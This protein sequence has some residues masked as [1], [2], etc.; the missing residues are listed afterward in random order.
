MHKE[1]KTAVVYIITKLE[2]GGAQKICLALFNDIEQQGYTTH[3]ITSAEGT[4]VPQV[5]SNPKAHLLPS[6]TREVRFWAIFQEIKNFFTLMRELRALKKKYTD[7][8]VHTHSTKAGIVGRWAARLVGIKKIIHTVHGFAFHNFQSWFTWTALY[9]PEVLTSLITTAFIFVSEADAA[10]ASRLFPL[11]SNKKNIIRAAIDDHLFTNLMPVKKSPLNHNAPFIVGTIS[12]FKPQKN[13]LDLLK[14]FEIAYRANPQL[15]LEVIGDGQQ[16]PALEAFIRHHDLSDVITLHGWQL[17]VAD[18]MQHWH[19]FALSSLWEGLPCALI[20]ARLLKLPIVTYN[21]GGISDIIFHGVNGLVYPQKHWQQL[22]QGILL[23]A[24]DDI[25][26]AT[27]AHYPDNLQ[28]FTRQ[29]M[30]KR[31]ETL[32]QQLQ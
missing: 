8:I 25:L 26:Y 18:I 28:A 29:E 20:E 27:L 10:T 5:K 21:T 23:L 11:V 9:I 1:N 31:H 19:L 17:K 13:L 3:L 14:A 6:M 16:R 4:L 32:Y 24:Q 2:L 12:C 22:A 7:I 30:I 15:R